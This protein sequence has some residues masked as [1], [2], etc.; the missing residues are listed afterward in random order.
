MD[1]ITYDD[2]SQDQKTAYDAIVNGQNAILLGEGGSGKST[3]ANLAI[4]ELIRRKLNVMVCAP[5]AKSSAEPRRYY[6]SQSI[7]SAPLPRDIGQ[8]S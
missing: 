3:V 2:L 7:W 1:E 4:D 5:T 6:L 8:Y